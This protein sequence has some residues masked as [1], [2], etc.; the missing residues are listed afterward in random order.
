[1]SNVTIEEWVGIGYIAIDP[2]TGAGAYL[3]TGGYNGGY[4]LSKSTSAIITEL[5]PDEISAARSYI[6]NADNCSLYSNVS[7]TPEGELLTGLCNR[8]PDTMQMNI[9]RYGLQ[10]EFERRINIGEKIEW[11]T[12]DHLLWLSMS[13]HYIPADYWL[14]DPNI[15]P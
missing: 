10:K 8:F 1:M 9:M 11:Y 6:G 4:S 3:I 12:I 7:N 14:N 2:D 15:S 13:N 5:S